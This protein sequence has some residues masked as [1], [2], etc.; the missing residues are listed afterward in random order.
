MECPN[1]SPLQ[2]RIFLAPKIGVFCMSLIN[3]LWRET[4]KEVGV[5]ILA[6][7]EYFDNIEK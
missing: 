1:Y 4:V 5:K 6:T 2:Q 3:Y 7:T